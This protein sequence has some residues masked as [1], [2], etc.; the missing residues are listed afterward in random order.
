M[1]DNHAPIK[2]VPS[3]QVTDEILAVMKT[4]DKWRKLAKK[5]NNPLA[6]HKNFERE[7][8]REL[9]L[10]EQEYA[11]S[12]IKK[13]PNNIGSLWKFIRRCI[14]VIVLVQECNYLLAQHPFTPRSFSSAQQFSFRSMEQC[15]IENI[16]LSM[17]TGKAPGADKITLR[18]IKTVSLLFHRH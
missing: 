13:N 7:V 3:P 17:P 14:Q 15:E 8:R 12:E 10:A 6:W 2:C 1:L 9:R 18:V 5:T 11:T 4:R 16:I